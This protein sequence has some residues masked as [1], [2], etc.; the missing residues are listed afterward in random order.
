M[1]TVSARAPLTPEQIEEAARFRWQLAIRRELFRWGS[2]GPCTVC[3]EWI[4]HFGGDTQRDPCPC[5][6]DD[7]P[8]QEVR[9]N[10][11]TVRRHWIGDAIRAATSK[12]KP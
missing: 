10:L 12:E 4:G 9:P 8:L 7:V 5:I 11:Y 6:P 1:T 3:N 2:V